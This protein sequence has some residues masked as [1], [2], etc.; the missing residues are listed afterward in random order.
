[1][2]S[3]YSNYKA[4]QQQQLAELSSH[5]INKNGWQIELTASAG[6][7]LK[8]DRLAVILMIKS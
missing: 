6:H 1:M 2:D 8:M 5:F 3:N 7:Q 4:R